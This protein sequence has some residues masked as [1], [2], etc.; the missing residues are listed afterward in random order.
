VHW[1]GR[2]GIIIFNLPQKIGQIADYI[3]GPIEKNAQFKLFLG[4]GNS[5]KT[6]SQN[7]KK[8]PHV[9]LFG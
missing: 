6:C 4:I 2:I 8:A 1:L 5:K 3:G 7:D 9:L